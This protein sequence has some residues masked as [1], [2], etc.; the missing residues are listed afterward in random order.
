MALMEESLVTALRD[1]Q[2]DCQDTADTKS[3]G[4]KVNM[5][6]LSRLLDI[7]REESIA[8]D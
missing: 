1:R 7:E 6:D 8:G 4:S 5:E 2:P 3:E